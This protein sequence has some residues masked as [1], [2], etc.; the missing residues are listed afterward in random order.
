MQQ[1]L[2][3]AYTV[4]GI[5]LGPEKQQQTKQTKILHPLEFTF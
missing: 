4:P 1:I 2:W 3:G 5:L